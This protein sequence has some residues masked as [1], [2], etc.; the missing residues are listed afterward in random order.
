M[1]LFQFKFISINAFHFPMYWHYDYDRSP[2]IHFR[3]MLSPV[4]FHGIHGIHRYLVM[5]RDLLES[6]S[7]RDLI[8]QAVWDLRRAST[9]GSELLSESAIGE[10]LNLGMRCKYE[11][12]GDIMGYPII[13]DTVLI[14]LIFW[15]TA[16][17]S[18]V[19]T[20]G[21]WGAHASGTSNS[22]KGHV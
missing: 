20:C 15:W 18:V 3:D 1:I 14:Q 11:H 7:Q 13:F 2:P 21:Q 10:L 5:L 17:T 12:N 8:V 6:S 4:Q 19:S 16:A 22:R 9:A